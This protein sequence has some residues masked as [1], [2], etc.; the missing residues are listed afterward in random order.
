MEMPLNAVFAGF[1]AGGVGTDL[2]TDG[3]PEAATRS[4]ETK[5]T[6]HQPTKT[7]TTHTLHTICAPY[8]FKL[9]KG[10]QRGFGSIK[11]K[12]AKTLK[13]RVLWLPYP[14][15][16]LVRKLVYRNLKN[17][18]TKIVSVADGLLGKGE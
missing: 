1:A 9:Y 18:A 7:I 13:I 5:P 16:N 8:S 12:T 11:R 17:Y 4:T 3:D 14:R 6:R 10:S 2:S 15:N